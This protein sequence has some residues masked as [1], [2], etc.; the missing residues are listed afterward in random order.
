MTVAGRCLPLLAG[1]TKLSSG[2][3]TSV[4]TE[5]SV[6]LSDQNHLTHFGGTAN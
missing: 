4:I 3:R 5:E 1:I 6:C 2:R